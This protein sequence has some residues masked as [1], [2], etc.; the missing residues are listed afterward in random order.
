MQEP[1]EK[2]I[3][4][5]DETDGWGRWDM[6]WF[7]TDDEF[8]GFLSNSLQSSSSEQYNYNKR[9]NFRSNQVR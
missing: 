7:N 2:H 6:V 4:V 5:L 3:S 8:E 1:K 9:T